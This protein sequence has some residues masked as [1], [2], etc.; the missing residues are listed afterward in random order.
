VL[1]AFVF[2]KVFK[3]HYPKT[4]EGNKGQRDANFCEQWRV[5]PATDII[6]LL[7]DSSEEAYRQYNDKEGI[8]KACN[9]FHKRLKHMVEISGDNNASN[10]VVKEGRS[11][12]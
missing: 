7:N 1:F 8:P 6:E 9:N 2:N 11:I 12:Y 3:H 4:N 10:A 5:V